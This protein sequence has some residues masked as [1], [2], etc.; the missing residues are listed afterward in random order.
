MK[1]PL[2]LAG[3][4]FI[5]AQLA[6]VLCGT[7]FAV[8]CGAVALIALAAYY[9]VFRSD[10]KKPIIIL[11][12][13]AV[14]CFGAYSV[15]A[16]ARIAPAQKLDGRTV[17]I[18]GTVVDEPYSSNDRYYYHIKTDQISAGNVPDRMRIRLTCQRGTHC[19]DAAFQ[20]LVVSTV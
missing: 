18:Q 3:L 4:T 20:P 8:T 12:I 13:S 6:A 9:A 11:L 15:Y 16:L 1:R 19:A 5:A 14:A 2:L 7:A 10:C 17:R